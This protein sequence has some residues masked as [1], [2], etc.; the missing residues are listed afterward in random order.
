[1]G[2]ERGKIP[3]VEG[4]PG[5]KKTTTTTKTTTM[6]ER[7][8]KVDDWNLCVRLGCASIEGMTSQTDRQ[9]DRQ[10][11]RQTVRQSDSQTARQP[12]SWP[13]KPCQT[14]SYG[15]KRH[16]KPSRTNRLETPDTFMY[17]ESHNRTISHRTICVRA[18]AC[19]GISSLAMHC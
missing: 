10:P 9:P 12:E 8:G 16:T 5:K 18:C 13:A 15:K 1:M 2:K 11:D 3:V 17:W 19:K 14:V 4:G 7:K 6:R